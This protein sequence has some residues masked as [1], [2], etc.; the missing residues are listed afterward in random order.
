[1]NIACGGHYC[2]TVDNDGKVWA[3]GDSRGRNELKLSKEEDFDPFKHLGR[4][5]IS[6]FMGPSMVPNLENISMVSCGEFYS[7]CVSDVGKVWALVTVDSRM[8]N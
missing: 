3:F 4:P 2:L 7:F 8:R 5:Q 1:M 6:Y